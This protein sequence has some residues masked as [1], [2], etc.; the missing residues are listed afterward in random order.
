MN[1]TTK[2][3]NWIDAETS[4]AWQN[5]FLMRREGRRGGFG[6]LFVL[7]LW[8]YIKLWKNIPYGFT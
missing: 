7:F 2:I 6:V 5:P 4:S 3:R 1:Y 8:K